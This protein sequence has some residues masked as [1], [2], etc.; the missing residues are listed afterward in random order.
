MRHTAATWLM[1]AGTDL[2]EAAGYLGMSPETLWNTY[3]KHH[4]DFQ[5]QAATAVGGKRRRT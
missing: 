3:G 4:P 1:Q 5:H 2:Y